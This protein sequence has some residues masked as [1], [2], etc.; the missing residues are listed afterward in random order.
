MNIIAIMSPTGVYYKDE[1]IRE[2]HIAL[3][4]MDFQLVYPKNSGDLLK[5]IEANARICGVIFDWDDYSLELCSDI[6]ELNEYL[7]L[8]AFINTHSTFDVSL[9][10]MRMALYFFEYALNAADD[11]A[12]RIQQY[13]D[14]YIDTITP[15]LTKALFKYVREGKYTFCTPGHMAGTAFQKSPVGCLFYDFFGANT[16]KADV[17]ISVTE[18]GSL[19]DHTGPHLEAEEYIA[20]TFNAEQSY[21]VTNGTS[22]ANKI[23]GMYSAPTGSTVLIDRNCHKSLCHLLMMSDIVP[24]YLR[25]LRNAYGILGGIPQHEFTHESI[26]GRVA[27]TVNASWPVHA[28]IT[29]ST[30]DGLLYNTDYIKQTLDVPSIHFDS[31][32]VPYTNFHPIY[33]GK[34]G[35]SGERT[36]GKV[37]Y[38][39]QSTHKLLAAFSQ[40][41]M[42]H[43]KGDY[44][45]STFNEAYMMHTTTS[46]NYGIVASMET[47]A[48]MLRGNPGRCLINRSVERALH[49]RREVQRLRGESDSWF[50]DIWQ[51]E[52][53]DEAQ[54]WPLNPDDNW[55]GFGNTD[56]DHMYLDPIKV[57]ILTPGMN[58]LGM[59]EDSGIPA[60][61]VAKYL[62]ERGI[63]VEK[64]GPYNLLFLFSIGIDKTKAMSLLRGLTDFKRAYDLNLRVKN[65]LPDLF[66]EDPD[67]YRNMR[68]QDLAAGIHSLIRRHDL[69]GLMQRAFDVLPE[70]KLTPHQ[71]FQQQVRGNV[72]T[73]ELDQLVGKVAANMILPYPPGVPLVMPGE[74]ITEESRAVLDFLLMLCSIGERYPGF[75]TDI[76]GAKLTE[77]GRYLVKVLKT[78][79]A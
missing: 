43:I 77:D 42:I 12:Q 70:M 21:L 68:I 38:E 24:I 71:M 22:T 5:L 55:H 4:A 16:L 60:A 18:L 28:V 65:M 6:N 47:A 26:A 44:D 57:T 9:H 79:L 33:D 34:S 58:E 72:E 49:F 78:P 19:L 30:Y 11:I 51:P 17:S 1:P 64:T 39:T 15:P 36:P 25:P 56:C 7:P 75:E 67:F 46:P 20:R 48:A 76:H 41:S 32:W 29:N 31:A 14:E 74:M 23:V 61:L 69:P 73:C 63:V 8:Y 62:D 10:E 53:I 13:T 54:C 59:L 27:A 40:A 66:A 45:E 37:I 52:E 35:M 3:T 50:F 2:L